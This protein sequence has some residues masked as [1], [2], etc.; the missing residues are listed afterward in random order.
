MSF[1]RKLVA[2]VLRE[3]AQVLAGMDQEELGYEGLTNEEAFWLSQVAEGGS[4]SDTTRA[5]VLRKRGLVDVF[6]PTEPTPD[7]TLDQVY[8]LTDRGDA[9]LR[10]YQAYR[11]RWA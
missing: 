9:A 2:Q 8:F 11:A 6:E 4:P 3:A 1:N 10:A 5:H 7:H